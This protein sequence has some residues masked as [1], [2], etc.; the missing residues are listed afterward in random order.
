M[1]GT[2]AGLGAEP[3]P[4]DGVRVVEIAGGIPAAFA[5]RQLGGFGAD[6]VRVEGHP[7]APG[8]TE[9]EEVYLV[10]GK[11]RVEASGEDLVRLLLAADIIVEDGTPGALA[12]LGADPVRLRADRPEVILVSISRFG[13]SGPYRAYRAT[14][15]VSFAMGGIMSLTGDYDRS[16]L[17]SGGSQADYLAGL[18][19][20][21]AAV[22]AYYGVALHGEGD[23][24][25]ISAQ[26]C[27]AGMLEL[28][29]PLVA[30]GYPGQ[31]RLG[32]QTRAE[33]GIFP[34]ADGY[35]GFF[36]LQR[37]I[38]NLF[39]AMGDP[40]LYDG[41]FLD[42]MYRLEHH[43]E[44][45]AKMFL[46][47]VDKT[48][49]ELI[50]IGRKHKV[51]VGAAVTPADL[52]DAGSLA[53]RGFWDRVEVGGGVATVPGRPFGGVGWRPLDRLH[54]PGEDTREIMDEW[55]PPGVGADDPGPDRGGA[56]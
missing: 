34:C 17:A 19:G 37:Q 36:A 35:I 4:L 51:P 14:N 44:L 49:E 55:L 47:A 48:K 43:D 23:W 13:Q 45:L 5:A 28:Y 25:D 8:L 7:V 26:E 24:I 9:D 3:L 30:Y 16:P 33:W 40:E 39:E 21:S 32:N 12:A 54:R 42:P 41:P 50:S 18:H 11:R 2:D 46:F 1:S 52:L 27:A 56:R 31:P 6:V 29:G 22:T 38:R 53:E 15:I 10:A 20:F